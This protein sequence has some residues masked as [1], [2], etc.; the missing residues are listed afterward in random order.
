D[1]PAW[2]SLSRIE[3]GEGDLGARMRHVTEFLLARFD[4]ALLL[5]ADM[6]QITASDIAF[7]IDGLQESQHVLGPS[8]DGGF[9]LFATRGNVPPATWSSTPWSQ[10]DTATRFSAALG[11]AKM[12][13]LRSLR[14]V[15]VAND[16]PPLLR[17]LDA[18][19]QPLTEQHRLAEWLRTKL[20]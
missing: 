17:D 13:R 18:L 4:A 12:T 6:P 3:Q 5:G 11:D 19:E 7:A 14:D 9:W 20:R 1:D 16:L 10:A 2:A 8:E 15:D